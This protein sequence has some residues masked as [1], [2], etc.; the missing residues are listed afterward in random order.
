[1]AGLN[2][3]NRLKLSFDCNDQALLEYS[4]FL[5]FLVPDKFVGVVILWGLCGARMCRIV[6][7]YSYRV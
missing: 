1:M 5:L 2:F 3:G 6:G 7:P 4:S